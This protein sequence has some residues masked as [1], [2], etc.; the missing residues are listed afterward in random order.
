MSEKELK[1]FVIR[2]NFSS[3]KDSQISDIR[4]KM[5]EKGEVGILVDQ[6][7]E[8]EDWEANENFEDEIRIKHNKS[9]FI[10]RWLK[11][12]QIILKEDVLV[13]ASYLNFR[14]E[15]WIGK[16]KKGTKRRN[17]ENKEGLFYFQIYQIIRNL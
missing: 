3:E 15:V 12:E 7:Y 11:M 16:I 4:N 1:V 9:Q 14:S 5:R 8:W 13:V 17:Y 6:D 2:N 10:S